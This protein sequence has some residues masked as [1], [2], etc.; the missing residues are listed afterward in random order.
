MA[1]KIVK[2]NYLHHGGKELENTIRG[3]CMIKH[4]R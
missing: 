2:K 4:Q 3:I 1:V